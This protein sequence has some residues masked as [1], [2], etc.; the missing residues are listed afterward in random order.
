[1]R[2]IGTV[3][4]ELIELRLN[5]RLADA[6]TLGEAYLDEGGKLDDG[7]LAILLKVFDQSRYRHSARFLSE[8]K[9]R[10]RK[11]RI[12][13]VGLRWEVARLLL[14]TGDRMSAGSTP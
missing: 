8:A 9:Q 4:S 10:A 6:A 2:D 1:M 3:R 7:M 11:R 5:N 14:E 13:D 12:G